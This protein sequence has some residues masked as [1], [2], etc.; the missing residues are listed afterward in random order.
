MTSTVKEIIAQR[1]LEDIL[2]ERRNDIMATIRDT[3]ASATESFG[4]EVVDIRIGRSELPE[5]VSQNVYDRMVTERERQASQLRAEGAEIAQ[6]IRAEAER[7]QVVLVAQAGREVALL[8]GEGAATRNAIQT[9]T[10]TKRQEFL[11]FFSS[12]A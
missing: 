12:L 9:E 1:A 4:I 8:P 7:Q 11:E 6:R 5:A 3:V 10:Y 2:S